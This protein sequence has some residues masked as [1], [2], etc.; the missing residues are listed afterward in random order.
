MV[1]DHY[2]FRRV[3]KK[4]Q[5]RWEEQQLFR[6]EEGSQ[7]PK[8]Y[9]LVFFPYPTG[10]GISVG[11]CRNYIPVDVLCRYKA[12]LGFNV[13]QPMGWDAF[14]QPAEN[15]AIKVKRNPRQMVPEYAANYK[16]QLTLAG[17]SY[18]W[19][20]EIDSSLPEYYRWTQY[21]FLWLYRRGLAYRATTPINWC[22][23][24]KTGLAN[25]E[26]VAGRCWRCNSLVEKRPMPQWYFRITAYAERLLK[27]LDKID[28]PEGIKTMQR[29]W[30]G[31]SDGAEVDFPIASL[32]SAGET[33][34]VFTTRPDTLWGATFMVIAPEHPLVKVIT[35]QE[36][37]DAVNEY[38]QRA[39]RISEKDRLSTDRSKTGVFTGAFATNPVNGEAIPIFIADYVLMGYGTGAI[40]SVPAHDQRDFEFAKK[41]GLTIRLVYQL[42]PGQTAETLAQAFH[43]GGKM[44]DFSMDPGVKSG[45]GFPFAGLP[46]Q[47]ATITQ[48]IHWLEE[49]GLGKGVVNYRLRDWLISRQRY[50]G[51]PIPMIHCDHC[52]LVPVPEDELPVYLPEVENYRPSGTGESPLAEM[53]EFVNIRCPR[54]GQPARRE[55]DTMGGFACSSWY[56]L[57]F[58]DPGN[59]HQAFSKESVDYWLPV[60]LYSGGA[61]HAVMHLLYARFWTKVFYDSGLIQFDEPFPRLKSQGML[62]TWTPG[63]LVGGALGS[64]GEVKSEGDGAS[65]SDELVDAWKVLK[66]EEKLTIPESE[67]VWRWI[68][69]SKSK[70]NVVT[71]DEI[72]EKYG[73]DAL[74]V[75][76]L[77]VAPFEET[78][79]WEDTGV[80]GAYRYVNRVWKLWQDLRPNANSTWRETGYPRN[81]AEDVRAVRRKLHQVIRKV[82]NDIENFRFNTAVAALMELTNELSALRNS[83]S[84][85]SPTELERLLIGEVVETF[86]LLLAPIAPHLAEE[87]WEI[88]GHSPSV[89]R[90]PWPRVDEAAAAEEMVEVV[91]QVNGKLRDRISVPLDYPGADLERLALEQPKVANELLAGEQAG[92]KLRQVI[93]IPGK[94]VNIVIR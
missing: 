60:D 83:L 53:A 54:C 93:V 74:R 81:H 40:M 52:G 14:G 47:E 91:L 48:V 49:K 61:E 75:Y 64:E 76:T 73:A 42:A 17:I 35:S 30:I 4:W 46:N 16:R 22:P 20:R 84:Q 12:M 43:S 72:A 66:P 71:P 94:L 70:G 68:K 90:Q 26:V 62:L 77:F 34:R 57:R 65:P 32:S 55:T 28:W 87:M 13:L 63:R 7:K 89:Y 79:K 67:W 19:S 2:D 88:L 58:A 37:R 33:L 1:D 86:P 51:A 59:L 44:V 56:F 10:A 45:P 78:V 23:V 92:K 82:G 6:A 21:F 5:K 39:Q 50:W 80:Q 38:V 8:F 15:E 69:M 41:F 9:G 29:E 24:D 85:R 11:H 3:E 27:D 36:Q 25:E 31:R 18:D